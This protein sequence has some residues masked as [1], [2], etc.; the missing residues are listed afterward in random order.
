MNKQYFFYLF[1]SIGYCSSLFSMEE[2]QPR[3][4]EPSEFKEY[5]P[6]LSALDSELLFTMIVA[7]IP[8]YID[9][10]QQFNDLLKTFA[11]IVRVDK[12]F[13]SIFQNN[14]YFTKLVDIIFDR[15]DK[16][17]INFAVIRENIPHQ[18]RYSSY[19]GPFIIK[20]IK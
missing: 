17:T 1:L 12:K 11:R 15:T 5:Q 2:Q 8:S 14:Y 3:S 7:L 19:T 10:L 18:Y 20:L 4:P 13:N 9:S 16:E 6:S